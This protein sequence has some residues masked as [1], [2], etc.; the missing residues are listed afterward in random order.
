MVVPM[1]SFVAQRGLDKGTPL[2]PY[3]FVLGME[4][5]S[6]LINKMVEG[7]FLSGYKLRDRGG[8]EVQVSHLLFADDTQVFCEDSRDQI[9]YL[10]WVLLWF[11]S[12]SG[13]RINLDKSSILPVGDEENPDLLALKLGCKV[14]SLPKTY[15]GL[16]LGARHKSTMVWD[17][18]E[19]K[20]RKRLTLWKRQYI[21]K[22]G[23]LA[24]IQAPFLAC[25]LTSCPSSE[26]L[27]QST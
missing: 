7:G 27:S 19:E 1:V 21:S 18:V 23:S 6:I 20:F 26:S 14:G 16:P 3:L 8:N 22:G 24:L 13:M 15:L 9:M 2:S 12:L 4:A 10:S 5:L 25:L 17:A 11:E